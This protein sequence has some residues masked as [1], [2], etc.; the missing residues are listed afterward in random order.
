MITS[1]IVIIG[2]HFK[3]TWSICHFIVPISPQLFLFLRV[4]ITPFFLVWVLDTV[5]LFLI[6]YITLLVYFLNTFLYDIEVWFN[7]PV[8]FRGTGLSMR[9]KV[10]Y[11]VSFISL[12][13]CVFTLFPSPIWL[14]F[15]LS[16]FIL[17]YSG[18]Q[19]Y[20]LGT[21]NQCHDKYFLSRPYPTVYLSLKCDMD[22]LHHR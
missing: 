19:G 20:S 10:S 16:L 4:P 8:D 13:L 14:I 18:T 22:S 3:R 2:C 6:V 17:W 7:W 9:L 12:S 21:Y 15:F 5:C 1:C 11:L